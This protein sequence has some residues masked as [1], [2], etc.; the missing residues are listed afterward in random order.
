METWRSGNLVGRIYHLSER[1]IERIGHCWMEDRLLVGDICLCIEHS[2][3]CFYDYILLDVISNQI[4]GLPE[5]MFG[6]YCFEG[7]PLKWKP[8]QKEFHLLN[9]GERLYSELSKHPLT[10]EIDTV[11]NH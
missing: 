3:D 9:A 8:T 10:A 2:G 1:D 7:P 11:Y 4:M 6:A 5:S